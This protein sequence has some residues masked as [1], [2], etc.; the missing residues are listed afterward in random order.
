VDQIGHLAVATDSG[1]VLAV[2]PG[3]FTDGCPVLVERR[4]DPD[5]PDV[6]YRSYLDPL[7]GRSLLV[8]VAL[9]DSPRSFLVNP[10]RW[11]EAAASA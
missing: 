2:A 9:A 1:A 4:W 7:S 5:G 10:R 8:E 11:S 3:H 6:V